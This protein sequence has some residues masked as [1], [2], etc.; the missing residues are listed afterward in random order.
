MSVFIRS[1]VLFCVVVFASVFASCGGSKSGDEG[2][3]GAA[4]GSISPAGTYPV[5]T[6][7]VPS[8]AAKDIAVS[9]VITATFDRDMDDATFVN[10]GSSN[11]TFYLKDES[12][13][14]V[15]GCAVHY[16]N[17]SR[18][19]KITPPGNLDYNKKYIAVITADVKGTDGK[20][21]QNKVEWSFTT[22]DEPDTIAPQVEISTVFPAS[23]ATN[24]PNDTVIRATFI[25]NKDIDAT[26]ISQTT[27]VV[28]DDSN[29]V[30]NGT[31]TYNSGNKTVTFTPATIIR[32]NR[33]YTVTLTS[34]IKDTSGNSLHNPYSWSF[35]AAVEPPTVTGT[36][37][38]ADADNVAC[39]SVIRVTFSEAMDATSFEPAGILVNGGLLVGSI[40][41]DAE[42]KTATFTPSDLLEESSTYQVTVS[43]NVLDAQ[44]Y[45]MEGDYQWSFSTVLDTTA[46][47]VSSVSPANGSTTV[48]ATDPVSVSFSEDMNEASI[49]AATFY[50]KD[51]FNNS[52]TG[53]YSYDPATKT[54]TL[55]PASPLIGKTTYTATVTTGVEDS[56][57]VNLIDT[58]SWS[59]STAPATVSWVVMVYMAGD[60]S[61][62]DQVSPDL[63]EMRQSSLNGRKVRVIALADRSGPNNS[64]L[65]EISNGVLKRLSSSELG[66]SATQPGEVD[67]GSQQTLTAFIDFVKTNY[68][69]ENYS[70]ILWN[71]GGGWRAPGQ[72]FISPHFN[73]LDAK[74][75]GSSIKDIAWD[76]T[77]GTNLGNNM[78]QGA[79]A[80]KGLTMMCMDA[81]S[82][83][84]LET[85]YELRKSVTGMDYLV[86]SQHAEPDTG[87]QYTDLLDH[88]IGASNISAANF[89]TIA[90]NDYVDYY[91][92]GSDVTQSA[93]N[94]GSIE[95]VVTALNSFVTYL[96]DR[97]MS[98][99]DQARAACQYYSYPWYV[100]LYGFADNF[101]DASATALK[102]AIST[103][104]IANRHGNEKPGSH[105]LSINFTTKVHHTDYDDANNV[106]SIDF[107][108]ASTWDNFLNDN[109]F[110]LTIDSHEPADD[111]LG[112]FVVNNGYT[113]TAYTI[114]P[115]DADVYSITVVSGGSIT[116]S[117]TSV[118]ANCDLDIFLYR[119]DNF[120][121]P[122]AMSYNGREGQSES[123]S[124]SGAVIGKKYYLAVVPYNQNTYAL[125]LTDSYS[126]SFGG[127]AG[128][129]SAAGILDPA[130]NPSA[131]TNGGVSALAI[132]RDGKILLGG[133]FTSCNGVP[134]YYIARLN[135]D[136]SL[137]ASFSPVSGASDG[138]TSIAIQDD[139]KILIAGYFLTYDGVICNR[140]ARLNPN[141]TLD[142]TFSQQGSGAS[143]GIHSIAIQGDGKILIGGYFNQYNEVTRR[144][145]ARLNSDGSLD[146]SFDPGYGTSAVHAIVLQ[147][148]GKILLGGNFVEYNRVKRNYIARVHPDGS[149]DTTFDPG[150]G[151]DRMLFTIVI[152][153]DGKIIIGGGFS[154]YNGISRSGIARLNAD[155]S[156][157][158]TFI[159][160]LGTVLAV[161][162]VA[163]HANNKIVL[164]GD[165]KTSNGALRNH[166]ARL[167]PDGSL[168]V[169]FKAT[170]DL[171]AYCIAIQD[172]G[173][174]LI[175]GFFSSC[176]GFARKNIARLLGD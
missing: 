153:S 30:I 132:Q 76:D 53:A 99:L 102:N 158:D 125:N 69:A 137:D 66:L 5:V 22:C 58:Y 160:G 64:Y 11:D 86:F 154:K 169:R 1:C 77:S 59:F 3:G 106:N 140:I 20:L 80:G 40:S 88:Y 136:G 83:G 163:L 107:L 61:L 149:L 155:G 26:T 98:V 145:I 4:G 50:L 46:P 157:D 143:D 159:S 152:Q 134:R 105:G 111:D 104:V 128:Y 27:F 148:N 54:A 6:V 25:E 117:L 127:T 122:V 150:T 90:V 39:N 85:A 21:L 113:G 138:V 78:I 100:D 71:H 171:S 121:Q 120:N 12:E 9:S 47:T 87:Y 146:T 15:V 44:G 124:F 18:T 162:S 81:C 174:I 95:P 129:S 52:I 19:A 139:D 94:L 7:T 142:N 91:G 172:N 130:F 92:S 65:Y 96:E 144:C 175:G 97:T 37:P 29:T 89:A 166:I 48:A 133:S 141:G 13:N 161:Y 31:Y 10:D 67:T 84:M 126:I 56:H 23:N 70:L 119:E 109:T 34:G 103:A 41:Y 43:Q 60:N 131:A 24:V 118:P 147:D 123:I 79:V 45:G 73:F 57:G 164:V 72:K 16:T 173:N 167:N 28:K 38:A 62:S 75:R 151:G 168:D 115:Y 156:L 55:Q 176:N 108:A 14:K 112:G 135:G 42:T 2:G 35:T 63:E 93:V 101:T 33:Q 110:G 165:F 170:L 74:K 17:E 8:D 114:D 68:P 116:V 82:M 32:D 49:T 51:E 36:V